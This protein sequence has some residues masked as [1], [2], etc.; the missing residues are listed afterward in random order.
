MT[1]TP[2]RR[3]LRDAPLRRFS[4][5]AHLPMAL[6]PILRARC[7]MRD[8]FKPVPP[9]PAPARFASLSS[10]PHRGS[11]MRAI[12]GDVVQVHPPATPRLDAMVRLA[13]ISRCDYPRRGQ[14]F[15]AISTRNPR[16]CATRGASRCGQRCSKDRRN[17]SFPRPYYAR[18]KRAGRPAAIFP[19]S[20]QRRPP[21]SR[22]RHGDEH[23]AANGAESARRR[24]PARKGKPGRQ[25]CPRLVTAAGRTPDRVEMSSVDNV[26]GLKPAA[27][28]SASRQWRRKD[29]E[30][31]LRHRRTGFPTS[32]DSASCQR[33]PSC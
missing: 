19:P 11:K 13:Q 17:G 33:S 12:F 14:G 2:P 30:R 24:A 25:V 3:R 29:Q 5:R 26:R 18:Q 27:A 22:V 10:I 21:A 6:S 7:R 8:G 4:G 9:A 20:R 28:A 1:R 32:A 23:S 31:R 15:F 16:R